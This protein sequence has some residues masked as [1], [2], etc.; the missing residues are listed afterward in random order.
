MSR[1]IV[2]NHNGHT[3]LYR[4]LS[5]GEKQVISVDN[6]ISNGINS[7]IDI[8][9]CI[10]KFDKERNILILQSLVDGASLIFL[11]FEKALELPELKS[12][13]SIVAK[14]CEKNGYIDLAA[15]REKKQV[16]RRTGNTGK[17]V[18][19]VSALL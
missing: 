4:D 3:M 15:R 2:N 19:S 18:K 1:F 14:L 17:T 12:L 8:E 6:Q 11:N 13:P 10:V 7:I 16:V 9:Q 5:N